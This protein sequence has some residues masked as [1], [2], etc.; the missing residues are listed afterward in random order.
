[1]CL[2]TSEGGSSSYTSEEFMLQPLALPIS[3]HHKL[4]RVSMCKAGSDTITFFKKKERK[5]R[6]IKRYL[7]EHKETQVK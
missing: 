7:T 4:Q 1:M 5:E 3:Q 2:S 6:G